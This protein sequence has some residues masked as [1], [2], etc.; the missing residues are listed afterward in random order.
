M[1]IFFLG[2]T[3]LSTPLLPLIDKEASKT[4]ELFELFFFGVLTSLL[5]E[6]VFHELLNIISL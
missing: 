6:E 5:L 1:N 4:K 3:K 2:E